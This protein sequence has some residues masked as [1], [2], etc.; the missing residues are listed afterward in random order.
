MTLC[1]IES[2]GVTSPGEWQG[3]REICSTVNYSL[4]LRVSREDIENLPPLE[5]VYAIHLIETRPG[6]VFVIVDDPAGG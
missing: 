4:P 6:E 5:R 3:L 1:R 2:E